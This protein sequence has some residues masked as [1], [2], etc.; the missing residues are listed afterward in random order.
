M[1]LPAT[2][3]LDFVRARANQA[4]RAIDEPAGIL[5]LVGNT[6][7]V[8][9]RNVGRE[10]KHVEIYAKLES[11]NP[12]G[13]VKDRAALS[14]IRDGEARGAL[15][16]DKVIIDSSSGNTGV[17][18]SLIGAALGYKV[19]LVMPEN[20]TQA[21]KD[22]TRAF[23]TE[24]IFSDP[25]EGSDGAIRLVRKVVADEP[26]RFF[27]PDQYANA[28]NPRAHEVGTAEEIIADV[29]A[30]ITHFVAGI[31]TSGT[32]MGTGR[33][34]KKFRRDI[35]VVAAEPAEPLHGLEGLKHMASSI[36]P[37]IYNVGELDEVLSIDTEPAWDLAERLPHAEGIF[38][39]H[40]AG[41]G[42]L[43]A[44][45][46]AERLESRGESGVIVT[47]FPDGGDRYFA[48]LRWER[49]SAW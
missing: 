34:L 7:L 24:L 48:K 37:P 32:I 15:T 17:A 42:L 4:P 49:K 27:Y 31:G 8:R 6:P 29:G 46:I 5:R 13:S 12:G 35:H 40:S 28:A 36:V 14:M 22:I 25:L 33:G 41:A 20:V 38:V 11:F 21:R 2:P 30:R 9:M 3:L 1:T 23:G 39:G 26:G 10:F 19:A 16:K 44:L 45:K 43:G 47:L 18:Y